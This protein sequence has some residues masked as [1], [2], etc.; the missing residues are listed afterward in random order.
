[1]ASKSKTSLNPIT[2]ILLFIIGVL[3]VMLTVAVTN[4]QK[5]LLSNAAGGPTYEG[6]SIEVVG[7]TDNL[8]FG[9]PITFTTAVPKLKGSEYPMVSV[10]CTQDGVAVWGSLT[11]P[12]EVV[13]LG[14]GGNQWKQNGG[15]PADC[16]V[17]LY[18][19]GG[20]YKGYE[21]ITLLAETEEFHTN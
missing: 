21:K 8:T 5:N 1:M 6:A 16:K 13:T 18:S 19:F 12:D 2:I 20:K 10:T 15:G 11:H 4:S 17:G 9:S 7:G 3:V 14:S